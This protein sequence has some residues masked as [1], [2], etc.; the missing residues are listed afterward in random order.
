MVQSQM[1]LRV[2]NSREINYG[3]EN[4]RKKYFEDMK[5]FRKT[6]REE[7]WDTQTQGENMW[8]QQY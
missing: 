2:R 6:H 5:T 8:L 3:F 7:Y 4:E 1:G